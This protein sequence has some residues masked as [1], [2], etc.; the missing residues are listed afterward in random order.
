MT[1]FLSFF[2]IIL[3]LNT[4]QCSVI[5][6]GAGAAG[7]AAAAYLVDRG[8]NDVIVLE[9]ENR[10]GGRINT[11]PF[12]DGVVDLGA[13]FC[14]GEAGNR[15]YELAA[16]LKLLDSHAPG[17]QLHY[18]AN[19]LAVDHSFQE[20]LLNLTHSIVHKKGENNREG[21]SCKETDRAK[22]CLDKLFKALLKSA[23]LEE[24]Q[25]LNQSYPWLGNYKCASE[26]CLDLSEL[27]LNSDYEEYPG[28]QMLSF[29]S[30]GYR[31]ILDLLMRK[32]Q[33]NHL[34]IDVR[35]QSKVEK[36]SHWNNGSSINLTLQNGT[37][38]S[39]NQVIFTPSLGV[40]K[41]H[42]KTMFH[43]PLPI[44]YQSAFEAIGYGT[45]TKIA[46]LFENIWWH[47][48]DP[49]IFSCFFSPEHALLVSKNNL[50]WTQSFTALTPV[51]GNPKVLMSWFVGKE[52]PRIEDLTPEEVLRGLN[53]IVTYCFKPSFPKLTLPK[54]FVRS[55]WRNNEN[56]LG[57]YSYESVRGDSRRGRLDLGE[58]I[59][60]EEGVPV[61]LF[62][63][64]ATN[65]VNFAT[66]HGA[67]D[68][69]RK[70]AERV[71]ARVKKA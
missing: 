54:K 41:K 7:I 42:Y 27:S 35:L 65:S 58:V 45:I 71:V 28:D 44:E 29:S 6:I 57:A 61:L 25:L 62:A 16:P 4:C 39:A 8:V 24:L 69:G 50:T 26:S 53:F 33:E 67:I 47:E 40:L 63:G 3:C 19:G 55:Q 52:S 18:S 15:V 17:F 59:R 51:Q 22:E 48:D 70:M 14:H 12:G 10:I 9:A 11:V 64:E 56:F 21:D 34:K 2:L 5:V 13:E 60:N 36:I 31:T 23:E 66:V 46:L 20:K 30:G 1:N 43:P 32:Y 38:L 49:K 37:N 68:S